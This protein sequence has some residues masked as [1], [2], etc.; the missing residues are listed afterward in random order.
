MIS[1]ITPT[2]GNPIALKRTID[3]LVGVCDEFIIGDVCVFES[4]REIIESYKNDY[5][6][7]TV[8][9]PFDFIFKNGFSETLNTLAGNASNDLVLYLNVGEVVASDKEK[10]LPALSEEYNAYYIDHSQEK[11]RWWRFYDRRFLKWEGLLHEELFGDYI[12]YHKAIFRFADT[13]KDMVNTFKAAVYNSIKEC[14][15]WRQLMRLVDEPGCSPSTNEGWINFAKETYSSMKERLDA[16]GNG[17][18]AFLN[19]D[20]DMFVDYIT[21]NPE[22]EK[23]RYESSIA[24]EYQGDKLFLL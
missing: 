8:R 10:I 11:H 12:P 22:L 5:N 24:I 17:Y 9:L 2:Q 14:V 3:S 16:K 15:Y 7:K 21:N 13:D 18:T 4:D 19:G 20:F 1:L 23:E 6:I